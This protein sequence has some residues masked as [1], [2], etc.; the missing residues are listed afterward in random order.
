MRWRRRPMSC[1]PPTR[2]SGMSCAASRKTAGR[3]RATWF[4]GQAGPAG[5]AAGPAR[6]ASGWRSLVAGVRPGRAASG[7]RRYTTRSG[8]R[9]G[10]RQNSSKGWAARPQV[11]RCATAAKARCGGGLAN[12]TPRASSR[13]SSSPAGTVTPRPASAI[14]R[15]GHRLRSAPSGARPTGN[16]GHGSGT[17]SG[18]RCGPGACLRPRRHRAGNR[19]AARTAPS[20]R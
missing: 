1:G 19:P 4:R 12:T 14:S 17:N 6:L 15:P 9:L 5:P 2:P 8:A 7:M 10:R 16:R 3:R 13:A 20:R 11:W 18:S